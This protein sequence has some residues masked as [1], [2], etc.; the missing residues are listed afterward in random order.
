MKKGQFDIGKKILYHPRQVA[1]VLERERPF[2]V[3]ME[4]D[5]TNVCNHRC[6]FCI[7]SELLKANRD[8]LPMEWIKPRLE[9]AYSLGTRGISFTGGGEPSLHPDFYEILK[10]TKDIGFSVGLVTN[11]SLFHE[12]H[13]SVLLSSLQWMRISVAGGDRD[14]YRRVQGVDHF[15]RVMANLRQLLAE[16]ARHGSKVELGVRMLVCEENV[17]SVTALAE[18]L[19]SVHPV[20]YVQFAPDSQVEGNGLWNSV[21]TKRIFDR[22]E[23]ILDKAGIAAVTA[24]FVGFEDKK[25]YP[26]RCYA[27]FFHVAITASG[28]F[29]FCKCMRDRDDMILGNISR[30]SLSEIWHGDRSQAIEEWIRPSNCGAFCKCMPVNVAMQEIATPSE[31]KIINFLG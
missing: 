31:G 7:C 18:R 16:R 15:D 11:G 5:L 29:V 23:E 28:N 14:S 19:S 30:Q 17:E 27:H 3:T 2:P 12:R 20:D 21:A 9:E 8:V 25:S 10:Y 4:V 22:C 1:E 13:A 24:G 26:T 6:S